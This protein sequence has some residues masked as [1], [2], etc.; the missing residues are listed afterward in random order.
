LDLWKATTELAQV[1]FGLIV[2]LTIAFFWIWGIVALWPD[3]FLDT[4]FAALTFGMLLR[5]LAAIAVLLFGALTIFF[6]VYDV[7]K[8]RK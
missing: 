2:L 7:M 4:P 3:N 5:A 1:I 6:W 8:D